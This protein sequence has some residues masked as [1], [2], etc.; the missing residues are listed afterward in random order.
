M[1]QMTF[2]GL[3]RCKQTFS[4]NGAKFRLI[5]PSTYEKCHLCPLFSI[6]AQYVR[7]GPIRTNESKRT[8]NVQKLPQMTFLGLF[9]CKQTFSQNVAKFWLIQP[10]THE[11]WHIY[12]LFSISAKYVRIGPIR[13][14]ES[15]RTFN[16]Q[17][18]PQMTFLGLFRCKQT[19]SQNVAKFRLIQPSTHEKWHICQLFFYLG[20]IRTNRP[21]TYD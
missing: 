20:Q 11:K 7:I 1:P 19:F 8:F 3:F 16:V 4:Q 10:S 18:L 2:L 6:S 14:N 13:T 17:K 15:K 21:N 9:R 12:P 5:Q